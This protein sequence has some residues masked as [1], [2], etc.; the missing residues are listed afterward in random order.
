MRL[1]KCYFGSMRV[2]PEG[3]LP[4][5]TC[6]MTSPSLAQTKCGCLAGSV[7]MLPAGNAFM[8]AL[9][10]LFSIAHIQSAGHH[11]DD[12]LIGM[13]MGLNLE[14]GRKADAIHVH[15]GLLLIANK[16]HLLTSE[17]RGV[18]FKPIGRQLRSS[19]RLCLR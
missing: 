19:K 8:A 2:T 9:I 5:T 7:Q 18:P 15:A 6:T 10:E 17:W 3:P 4:P 16:C 1:A 14:I 11:G 13:E 12:P